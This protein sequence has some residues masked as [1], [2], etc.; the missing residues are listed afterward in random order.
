APARFGIP[1]GPCC[2]PLVLVVSRAVEV[3]VVHLAD[4]AGPHALPV[5]DVGALVGAGEILVAERLALAG[6]A[7]RHASTLLKR[8]RRDVPDHRHLV[9]VVHVVVAALVLRVLE[10]LPGAVRLLLPRPAAGG[11]ARVPLPPW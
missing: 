7:G 3:L 9:F 5:P 2:R 6:V 1:L 11:L 4:R 8:R 10:H